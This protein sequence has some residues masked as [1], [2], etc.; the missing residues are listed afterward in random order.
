MNTLGTMFRVTSFGESHGYGVGCVIDGCPPGIQVNLHDL[1]EEMDRRRA[2]SSRHTPR[3]E[4]DRVDILSGVFEGKTSGAPIVCLIQN[5]KVDSST[6]DEFRY[7]PRPSHADF[8]RHIKYHGYADYRGGGRFSGRITAGFV[9][10]GYFARKVLK[11]IPVRATIAEI[12]GLPPEKVDCSELQGDSLGGII[13]CT[14][15]RLPV[16]LGEP[17]FDTVEGELAKALFAIPGVKGIEFGTGFELARMRGSEANDQF[18]MEGEKVHTLTNHSGGILGGMT[19]GMML[20]FRVAVK[21]TPSISLPQKSV[22]LRTLEEK[23]ITIEGKHDPCIA[24]RAVPVV[25]AIT[26]IVLADLW[27]RKGGDVSDFTRTER[28]DR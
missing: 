17:V 21:P 13:K 7:V 5:V 19:S 25:E 15:K 6:Y 10:A 12:G 2:T 8:P 28:A 3:Q 26:A 22:D 9:T 11:D 1:Q 16:G 27:L 14:V 23:S 18:C 24:F 20:T 4:P